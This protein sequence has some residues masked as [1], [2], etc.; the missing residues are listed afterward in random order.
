MITVYIIHIWLL[1]ILYIL[2]NVFEHSLLSV[3]FE[4]KKGKTKLFMCLSSNAIWA[5]ELKVGHH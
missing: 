2:F 4:K 3:F 5:K 1:Y